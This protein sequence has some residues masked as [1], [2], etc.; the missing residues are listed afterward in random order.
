MKKILA[1]V[2]G[3]IVLAIA[4]VVVAGLIAPKEFKS[5]REIVINKPKAEVFAYIKML[6][7]QDIWGPWMKKDPAMKKTFRGEDGTV[8][9]ATGWD[10]TNDDVGSGEQEIKK[11]VEGERM[12]TEIRF[13]RP[14]NSTV[15]AQIVTESI[16]ENQTKVK[17]GSRGDV[18]FP[19]N[20]M[21]LFMDFDKEVGKDFE[22]GLS[23]L[24]QILEK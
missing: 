1:I 7:N 9:F 12:E 13:T 22:E 21:M 11:I 16:G 18:P 6:K 15:Q 23:S 17:W 14:F 5:E 4:A 3:L 19:F 2:A 8:G 10:S 20:A 24:K